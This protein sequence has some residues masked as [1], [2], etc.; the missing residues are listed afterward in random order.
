[1]QRN[2]VQYGDRPHCSAFYGDSVKT[3]EQFIVAQCQ[4]KVQ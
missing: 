3:A 1:M 2:T 4:W